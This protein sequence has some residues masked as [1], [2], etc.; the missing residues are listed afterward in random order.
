MAVNTEDDPK[1]FQARV[2]WEAQVLPVAEALQPD[3]LMLR[4]ASVG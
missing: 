3:P 4:Q 2:P 1:N